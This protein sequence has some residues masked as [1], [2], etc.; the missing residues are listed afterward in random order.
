MTERA[1]TIR[2]TI[3]EMANCAGSPHI[4]SALSCVDIFSALYFNVLH[5]SKEDFQK[6]D[7]FLLSKAHSAMALYATLFHK[8]LL[9]KEQLLGY[10]KSTLP[11]HT[12]RESSPY[13]EI[14]AG[15]LGHGLPIGVG[16]ALAL[17]GQ[18]NSKGEQRKVCVLMGDGEVQEGSVWEAAMFAP[19]YELGH[20]IALIDRNDLQGYGRA[21]ELVSYEKID[22]K[23]RAFGWEC[24]RVDGHNENAMIEA[25]V[26]HKG[27]RIPL[28]LVCDTTKGKGVSFMENSLK[29]HYFLVTDEILKE[30]LGELQ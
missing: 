14:S 21:S 3:L 7:I 12:D 30:S 24:Q 11:A 26:A 19:K 8:G 29:W 16:M 23:W 9:S 4:G 5:I 17:K 28:C 2:K 18:K 20:L 13:V 27:S 10:Y 6:R 22:E 25:I 15:S 1:K